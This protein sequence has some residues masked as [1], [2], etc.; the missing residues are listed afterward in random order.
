M[1][2]KSLSLSFEKNIYFEGE[3]GIALYI[4][5]YRGNSYVIVHEYFYMS[6][7]IKYIL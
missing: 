1:K 7:N 6:Y 2:K 3:E 4:E 5:L